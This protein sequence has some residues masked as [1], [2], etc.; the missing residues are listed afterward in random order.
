MLHTETGALSAIWRCKTELTEAKK[1]SFD[2][3]LTLRKAAFGCVFLRF[4]DLS[5]K[6]KTRQNS[7]L[8]GFCGDFV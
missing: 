3:H 4:E 8:A 7:V 1:G 5:E 2:A 6:L